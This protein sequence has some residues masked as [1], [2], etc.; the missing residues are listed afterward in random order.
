MSCIISLC[1]VPKP[2]GSDGVER[3]VVVGRWGEGMGW[4]LGLVIGW[5]RKDRWGSWVMP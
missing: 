3:G 5:V 1:Q 4:L 2:A